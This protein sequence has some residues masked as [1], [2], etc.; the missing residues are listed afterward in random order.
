MI[1][2]FSNYFKFSI[3]NAILSFII[4]IYLARTLDI[5]SFGMVGIF[6][7]LLFFAKP[8]AAFK[9]LGLVSINKVNLTRKEFQNFSNNYFSFLL[10]WS[11]FLLIV[12]FIISLFFSKYIF[13]I[14]FLPIL[15]FIIFL[16]EFH[17]TEL[18]QEEKSKKH[19]IFILITRVL[20]LIL[21]ILLIELLQ[22]NWIGYLWAI[23]ISEFIVLLFRLKHNFYTLNNFSFNFDLIEYKKII[24]YGAPLFLALLGGFILN[25]SDKFIVLNYFTLKE[26]AFYT[27]AY[28]IGSILNTI[29][30][31]L[32]NTVIP[33][34]YKSLRDSPKEALIKINKYIVYYLFIFTLIVVVIST[35][36]KFFIPLLYG[37]NY[38]DSVDIVIYIVIAFGFNGIYRLTGFIIEYYKYNALKT[39]LIIT[40]ALIN[41]I[42]SISMISKLALLAPAVGTVIAY[43]F[44][45]ISSQYFGRKI[46]NEKNKNFN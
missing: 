11:I 26:V 17:N 12:S 39:K 43:L 23:L 9:S 10:F 22:L 8:V 6:I 4:S 30:Q 33:T 13:I 15:A 28:Q 34:I 21:S 1:K 35:L 45:S 41:M 18:I 5:E 31:A 16:G 20:V 37:Q 24:V 14:I 3:L 7:A 42:F 32:T 46:L 2:H 36:T 25:Q 44:L 29:N 27:V 19:G 40:A 38:H